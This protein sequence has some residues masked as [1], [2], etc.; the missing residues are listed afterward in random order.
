M[1]Y[2]G[3]TVRLPSDTPCMTTTG[4]IPVPADTPR[5]MHWLRVD[6]PTAD[7]PP[8]RASIFDSDDQW[9]EFEPITPDFW[10]VTSYSVTDSSL[11][12]PAERRRMK[13][14][15][16]DALTGPTSTTE[17]S[18]CISCGSPTQPQRLV[19]GVCADCERSYGPRDID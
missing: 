15:L 7:L 19:N 10:A 13:A 9:V 5:W 4:V 12:S 16:D 6:R 3:V 14:R 11:L 18:T 1:S 2:E 8:N 17:G